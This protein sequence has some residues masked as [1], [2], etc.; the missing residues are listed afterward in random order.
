[1][2]AGECNTEAVTL[3]GHRHGPDCGHEMVKHDDHYDF[4]SDDGELHHRVE[5]PVCCEVHERSREP[6]FVSHGLFSTLIKGKGISLKQVAERCLGQDCS[7]PCCEPHSPSYEKKSLLEKD[8]GAGKDS[9]LKVTKI[10]C[11]GICCP[12]E[13][14]VIDSCLKKLNGVRQVEVAVVTKTVTVRHVEGLASPAAMVA[15]LNEARMDASLTFPRKQVQGARSWLPPWHVWV[16]AFLLIVSLFY[17][18]A[19][20]TGWEWLEYLK[21]VALGAVA[22]P[23]PGILLK[24]LGA[25]RHGIFDI[26]L[27]MTLAVSGA[28]AI[29][30]YTEAGTVVVLFSVADFLESR[31]TGQ[32]RDA[33]S[34]VLSLRPET[35]ILAESGEEISAALVPIGTSVLVRAGEKSALDGIVLSGTSAFDESMLTGES[36]PIVKSIGDQIKAGTMNTGNSM[37]IIRTETTADKTFVAGMAK[38]VEQATSRQSPSEAAVAKFAKVYTPLVIITCILLAFVPWSDP[39]AD[40]KEWVYLSLEVL[41]I[42]CPCALVLS[43]PVT[44]VSA[45]ARAAQAGVLIKGGLVLETLS[46][47]RV[48]SFDKTGT[49]TKGSFLISDIEVSPEQDRW[50]AN[51]ILRLLGSLERGS[52]HPF[53]AAISGKAA[54]LGIQ[55]DLYV[56][57]SQSI[58]GSGMMGIVDGYAVKAGTAAFISLDL[59]EEQ[60][61]R[62]IKA[63][64]RYQNKGLTTCFVSIDETFVCTISAKDVTRAEARESI[65]ALKDLGITP[66]MLTG[67]NKSVALAVG[68]EAGIEEENIHAELMPQDKLNLVSQYQVNHLDQSPCCRQVRPIDLCV[69]KFRQLIFCNFPRGTG[70]GLDHEH[71]IAHVGDGVNDAPALAAANVGIAMGVAGA[72]AALEAGD[73]ALF[74]NDLRMIPALERL[75]RSARKTI[76]FNIAFSVTTKAVVLA[77]AFAKLFTLWA[78]VLVDVGTALFVTLMG[79]R[80]LRYDFKLGDDVPKICI[81]ESAK[82]CS[83][84]TCCNSQ[85]WPP[86]NKSTIAKDSIRHEKFEGIQSKQGHPARVRRRARVSK[87]A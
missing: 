16:S 56:K 70:N 4:V 32:A 55:C 43:T 28:I 45:L 5:E 84:G 80:M 40:R 47:I 10:Y 74:T 73:V 24:A 12:M 75:S 11:E 81:G 77:L 31:C 68:R 7:L 64:E 35:A 41:V 18:L 39:N 29:G 14:P 54:S 86:G 22:L 65:S 33:I 27:L 83:S 6:L 62:L 69:Q 53:A 50:D 25:L 21:Y 17:Y 20:P 85:T 61:S 71:S 44:I 63:S 42:A 37:V 60:S 66:A 67:D 46:S 34:S 58:P 38:L 1:M 59:S 51:G 23:M 48:V 57:T 72:A 78:A 49:L 2:T 76:V 30:E 15:A 8:N 52:S 79:L 36:V 82:C 3:N 87:R 26:H 9:S 13:V 19:G